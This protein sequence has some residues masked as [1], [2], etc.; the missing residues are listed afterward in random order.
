MDFRIVPIIPLLPDRSM[1]NLLA[2]VL[3]ASIGSKLRVT[4]FSEGFLINDELCNAI[5]QS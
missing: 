5:P 2:F 1:D 3:K 4:E